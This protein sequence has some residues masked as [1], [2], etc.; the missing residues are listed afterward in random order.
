MISNPLYKPDEKALAGCKDDKIIAASK[1]AWP[2][3]SNFAENSDLRVPHWNIQDPHVSLS[4][5]AINNMCSRAY[6]GLCAGDFLCCCWSF[7]FLEVLQRSVCFLWQ[8]FI[9]ILILYGFKRGKILCPCGR[10]IVT[11]KQYIFFSLLLS[12]SDVQ[13][14]SILKVFSFSQCLL[15]LQQKIKH[16][17]W[18][19]SDRR[20][21]AWLLLKI[22]LSWLATFKIFL[23]CKKKNIEKGIQSK[24]QREG[25]KPGIHAYVT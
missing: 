9:L 4:S 5:A 16:T 7:I 6:S 21:V 17:N 23:F 12:H 3:C 18:N 19:I 14:P 13:M 11:Q 10:L 2:C 25:T 20:R 8:T 1:P 15:P 24:K 22:T